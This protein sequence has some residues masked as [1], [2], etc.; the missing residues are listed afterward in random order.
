[1]S[2]PGISI[3]DG[4]S[5]SF[6]HFKDDFLKF[7]VKEPS[8]SHFYNEDRSMKF[9]FSWTNNPWR[10]KDMKKEELST[11]DRGVGKILEKFS[12]KLPTKGL[13]RVYL[14]VHPLI[15]LEGIIFYSYR[16]ALCERDNHLCLCSRSYGSIGEKE[17][18]L[19]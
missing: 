19:V 10:Y 15:D 13:V 14:S 2:W 12:N 6:K 11:S 5:Q 17:P 1:V 9:P 4:F 18:K 16:Y 7:V 8:C 3:L